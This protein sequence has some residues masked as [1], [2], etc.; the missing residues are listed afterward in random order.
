M[1]MEKNLK[2]VSRYGKLMGVIMMVSGLLSAVPGLMTIV[3][4]IPGLVSIWLGYLMFKSGK[5]AD[6]YM[7]HQTDEHKEKIL[8]NFSTFVFT[9]AILMIVG[10]ALMIPAFLIIFLIA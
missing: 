4:A 1:K 2:R 7:K 8:V 9:Q 6:E 5:E 3:G 10:L